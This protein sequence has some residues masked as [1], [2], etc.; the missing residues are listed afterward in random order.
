MQNTNYQVN[1]Y[2]MKRNLNTFEMDRTSFVSNI[3]AFSRLKDIDSNED[4]EFFECEI[5]LQ[6]NC[7]YFE[8]DSFQIK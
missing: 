7:D 3:N 4:R 8:L 2:L 6:L 1:G 5:A